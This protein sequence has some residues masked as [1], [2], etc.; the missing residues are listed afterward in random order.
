MG[1]IT[2]SLGLMARERKP[3]DSWASPA[4]QGVES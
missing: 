4:S 1:Q 2:V 3:P